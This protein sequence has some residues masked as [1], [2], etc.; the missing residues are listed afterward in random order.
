MRRFVEKVHVA[1]GCWLWTAGR[2]RKGY[3]Q[4]TRTV[5][6]YQYHLYAHRI[7]WELTR[8]SIP[9]GLCVCHR[10]DNPPCCNPEHLFLGT[11]ADNLADAR[12]KG[13][14]VC[15][16]H[17]RKLTDEQRERVRAMYRRGLGRQL[18]KQFNVS[19]ATIFRAADVRFGRPQRVA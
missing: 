7:A 3:G 1:D 10:C 4:Y 6:G 12:Q 13:R 14:L 9:E 19:L 2:F 8:G 15:G 17:L 11:Q 5:A 18:A 16:A